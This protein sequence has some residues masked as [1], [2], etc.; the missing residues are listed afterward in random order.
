M[1]PARKTKSVAVEASAPSEKTKTRTSRKKA[2]TPKINDAPLQLAEEVP[3]ATPASPKKRGRKP[4]RVAAKVDDIPTQNMAEA[5]GTKTADE[6]TGDTH[7]DSNLKS[8]KA[9]VPTRD[10]LPDR[11]VRNTRPAYDLQPTPR[12]STQQVAAAHEEKRKA[13][14]AQQKVVDEAKDELARMQLGGKLGKEAFEEQGR[15]RLQFGQ[16]DESSGE[17]D[18]DLNEVDSDE[19]DGGAEDSPSPEPEKEV[20]THSLNDLRSTTYHQTRSRVKVKVKV[21]LEKLL[22]EHCARISMKGRNYCVRRE[23]K[24]VRQV[25]GK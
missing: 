20:R 5:L 3:T 25:K 15:R 16:N 4:K 13:L 12:R 21:Q 1:P 17:E 6:P 22:R 11:W 10:P 2:P 8:K 24:N 9:S 19:E 14:E 18:F 7:I 23:G